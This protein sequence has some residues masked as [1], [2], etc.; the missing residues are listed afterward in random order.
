MYRQIKFESNIVITYCNIVLKVTSLQLTIIF[1]SC[2]N[3]SMFHNIQFWLILIISFVFRNETV[4]HW[5][6]IGTKYELYFFQKP[7]GEHEISTCYFS[8]S[9]LW[10]LKVLIHWSTVTV[11]CITHLNVIKGKLYYL[12][13]ETSK[14]WST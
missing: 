10:L 2:D 9:R 5:N 3:L 4:D 1:E 8:F 7:E 14:Y 6:T 11:L 12:V 13:M